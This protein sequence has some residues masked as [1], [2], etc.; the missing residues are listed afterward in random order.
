MDM[1]TGH[2]CERIDYENNDRHSRLVLEKRQ[3]DGTNRGGKGL[4][5]YLA[6]RR[7]ASVTEDVE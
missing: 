6:E 1:Q 3:T 7:A 2:H 5:I 4:I